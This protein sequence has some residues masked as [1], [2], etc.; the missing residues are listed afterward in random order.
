MAAITF[1]PKPPETLVIPDALAL[2]PSGMATAFRLMPDA[3]ARTR[4]S[5][6]TGVR[7]TAYENVVEAIAKEAAIAEE[8]AEH[9]AEYVLRQLK[10]G[11]LETWTDLFKMIPQGYV[12]VLDTRVKG[13]ARVRRLGKVADEFVPFDR[14]SP[15][16]EN[17]T[18]RFHSR[19][20]GWRAT[21]GASKSDAALMLW[22]GPDRAVLRLQ[23]IDASMTLHPRE[24]LLRTVVDQGT[25]QPFPVKR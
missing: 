18:I 13:G 2:D 14:C 11:A 23:R 6:T 19:T 9:C 16:F 1:H 3:F 7:S 4:R 21:G 15:L 22:F 25:D 20:G 5:L 12:R 17:A 10:A 24:S 8:A